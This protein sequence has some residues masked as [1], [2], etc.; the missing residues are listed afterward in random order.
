MFFAYKNVIIK[1]KNRGGILDVIVSFFRDFL[2]GYVYVVVVILSIIGILACVIYLVNANKKLKK[3]AEKQS[4]MY[5]QVHFLSTDT[6]SASTVAS[7]VETAI[8]SSQLH[9]VGDVSTTNMAKS[10]AVSS[11]DVALVTNQFHSNTSVDNTKN[12]T[13]SVISDKKQ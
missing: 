4:Q 12:S 7:N 5:G 6:S 1:S 11:E 13:D 10:V 3:E 2:S 9:S 8:S